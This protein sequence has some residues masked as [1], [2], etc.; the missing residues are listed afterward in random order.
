MK[1]P[2]LEFLIKEGARSFRK[3]PLTIVSA[4][5]AVFIAIYMVEV[6]A[7]VV[8][9]TLVNV[10]LC[11]YLGVPLFISIKIFSNTQEHSAS[12]LWLYRLMGIGVLLLVYFS[13]PAAEDSLNASI[14]Y[15]RYAIFATAAH[16]LVSFSAFIN[17]KSVDDFWRFNQSLFL[18]FFLSALY[19]AV[20]FLGLVLALFAVDS[21]FDLSINGKRYFQIFIFIAGI[22]N[23]WFFVA[24]IPERTVWENSTDAPT[25]LKTMLLYVLMPLITLYFLILYSYSAKVVFLWD[26][27]KGIMTYMIIAMAVV[28]IL[29]V[30]L[31]YPFAKRSS[32]LSFLV[33]WY[34]VVLLPLLVMLFLAIGIRIED[35]GITI[36][37]Y[38][39]VLLAIWLLLISLYFTF[40]GSNIKVVPMTLFV[41]ILLTSFGPWGIFRISEMSQVGRLEA[42]LTN[43]EI[44]QGQ[45]VNEPIWDKTDTSRLVLK[46]DKLNKGILSDSLHNEVKSILDYLEDYHGFEE[47]DIWYTQNPRDIAAKHNV[48]EASVYMKML[49]LDYWRIT[50]NGNRNG[51]LS[52]SAATNENELQYIEGYDYS[53]KI[54]EAHSVKGRANTTP[55][56]L[57]P[58]IFLFCGSM[59]LELSDSLSNILMIDLNERFVSLR[60]EHVK[61][62]YTL[63]DEKMSILIEEDWINGKLQLYNMS[64]VDSLTSYR[65][66][67]LFSLPAELNED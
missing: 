53:I 18:R 35:Y 61:N 2:S 52:F 44:L 59:S 48:S 60:A 56:E 26:W 57:I 64:G 29:T 30:L 31:A 55:K 22:F 46:Q 3:F 58:G 10:L 67:L 16:L 39:T 11:G 12:K 14:S 20:L 6:D 4:M 9:L 5:L 33:K 34:Y 49:G 43:A 15:I 41:I 40:R 1:L 54:Y 25:G 28:G 42:I 24:G 65:G 23:T 66:N 38:I 13:L 62:S 45:V 47:I 19:S 63:P 8:S 17:D 21:L 51:Y 37:R 50:K 7:D 27:P 32:P 36:N